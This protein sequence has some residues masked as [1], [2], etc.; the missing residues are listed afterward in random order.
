MGG[1]A[2]GKMGIADRDGI[3]PVQTLNRETEG[4]LLFVTGATLRATTNQV[5]TATA[6]RVSP[7]FA[8]AIVE[9]IEASMCVVKGSSAAQD[10]PTALLYDREKKSGKIVCPTKEVFDVVRDFSMA[11]LLPILSFTSILLTVA[12]DMESMITGAFH[13]E[14]Y[15]QRLRDIFEACIRKKSEF[16]VICDSANLQGVEVV[17][18]KLCLLYRITQS[19]AA[20]FID[21]A[22]ENFVMYLVGMIANAM[23]RVVEN[24]AASDGGGQ[25]TLRKVVGFRQNV[26]AEA[27]RAEAV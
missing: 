23:V 16:Q 18:S 25:T 24:E 7:E 3:Q 19:F 9:S 6:K 26:L 15:A 14:E 10:L 4:I 12:S 8:E 17:S 13:Q 5:A 11:Y 21:D 20:E 22:M 1:G 2:F 27:V